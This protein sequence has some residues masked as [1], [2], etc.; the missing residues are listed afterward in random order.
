MNDDVVGEG[1]DLLDG[2]KEE[3]EER[4]FKNVG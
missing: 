1:K 3:E 2:E 4:I